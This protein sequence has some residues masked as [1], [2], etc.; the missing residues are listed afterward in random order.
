MRLKVKRYTKYIKKS[1]IPIAQE[2]AKLLNMCKGRKRAMTNTDIIEYFAK[3]NIKL[4][5][6]EVRHYISFICLNYLP[7]LVGKSNGYFVT[8]DEHELRHAVRSLKSR[9]RENITRAEIIHTHIKN[10]PPRTGQ[11]RLDFN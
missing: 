8:D 1:Q 5:A 3:K 6:P 4:E 9:A 7:T 11:L 2:M 10:N